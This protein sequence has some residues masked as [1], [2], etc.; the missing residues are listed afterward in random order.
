MDKGRFYLSA[1]SPSL[2]SPSMSIFYIKRGNRIN[3]TSTKWRDHSLCPSTQLTWRSQVLPIEPLNLLI[4]QTYP[5]EPDS[6]NS[7]QRQ[8]PGSRM[9]VPRRCHK[10]CDVHL[11]IIYQARDLPTKLSFPTTILRRTTSVLFWGGAVSHMRAWA[12]FPSVLICDV[13]F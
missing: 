8:H 5:G 4:C 10:G 1:I 13:R 7:L 11:R 2:F 6:E 3:P 12:S 9:L